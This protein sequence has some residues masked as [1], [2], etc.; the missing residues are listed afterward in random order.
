M[1][2][3]ILKNLLE[4]GVHFGHQSKRWNPKMKKYIFGERSGIY[5]I[6]L[7]K[8]RDCL[9]VA[10]DFVNDIAAKGGSVLFVGTKK[11]AQDVIASEATR[12][13]MP[14]INR[15]WMGGLLTNFSTIAKSLQKLAD[16]ERME[17]NGVMENLKKKE[18]A[19]LRKV[20]EKI[21]RDLGGVREMGQVPQAVFVVDTKRE[22]I[23]VREAIKLGVPVIGLLD[24]NCDP[25]L[26]DYPIP[27]NDDALKSIRI[28]TTQLADA[29]MEGRKEYLESETVRRKAEA[30][31]K[32]KRS[33]KTKGR[34]TAQVGGFK[35]APVQKEDRSG[36]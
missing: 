5:I 3:E 20:K 4:C 30:A 31:E 9:N 33:D 28:I 16:I 10:Q 23:A 8:T 13:G 21:L 35:A 36:S 18:V 25:D 6:D 26:I 14:H 19:S 34:E 12:V 22:E 15:R 2:D 29:I 24:T 1:T 7:E 27:G 17:E 32:G 11:Q